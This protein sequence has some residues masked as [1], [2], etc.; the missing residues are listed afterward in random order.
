MK[1]ILTQDVKKLGKTGDVKE[2]ADGYAR[3]FLIARGFARPA[4]EKAVASVEKTRAQ[5]AQDEKA[6]KEA[7]RAVADDLEGKKIVI[8]AKE[9]GGK[10]FGSIGAKDI[11]EELKK[12]APEAEENMISLDSPIKEVGE[13]ELKVKLENGIEAS[14]VVSVEKE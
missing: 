8:K 13:K 2:V 12:I 7:L 6:R 3:N 1:V 9:K 11:F 10:L 4:T 5:V 14:V